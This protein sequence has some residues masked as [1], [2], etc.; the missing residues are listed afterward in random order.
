MT[1]YLTSFVA[2]HLTPPSRSLL[3]DYSSAPRPFEC[4]LL[5]LLQRFSLLSV[6]LF[7]C[8]RSFTSDFCGTFNSSTFAFWFLRSQL[9]L[10]II[11]KTIGTL[12]NCA[13][14][15]DAGF[16]ENDDI[17]PTSESTRFD[18]SLM[19]DG[20]NLRPRCA[21]ISYTNK[22]VRTTTW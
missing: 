19:F 4:S 9:L 16:I 21:F 22:I 13:N 5:T 7:N 6:F 10:C 8:S 1:P 14:A 11:D 17:S 18:F 2:Y 15:V 12:S 20:V 3:L